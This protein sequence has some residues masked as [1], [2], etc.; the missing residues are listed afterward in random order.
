MLIARDWRNIVSHRFFN[1]INYSAS[2]EDSDSELQA[3]NISNADRVLCITGSGARTLDL[4][5]AVPASIT[6]VDLNP[7][8]NHLLALK[9]A[10]IEE[11]EHQEF[12]DFIGIGESAERLATFQ[13]I[14]PSLSLRS[15]EFWEKHLKLVRRGVIYC[16]T[17]ETLLRWISKSTVLRRQRIEQLWNAPDL[18]SQ[19]E[20]WRKHWTGPF[21]RNFLRLLATR[22][23]WTRIIRE[24]GAKLIDPKFDVGDYLYHAIEKMVR[25]SLIRENPYANLLFKGRYTEHCQLPPHLREEQFL[26]LKQLTYRIEIVTCPLDQLLADRPNSFD[27]FSLSDFSSYAP[28][29]AYHKI[30]KQVVYSAAKDSRFC[31]RQF[32][33]KRDFESSQLAKFNVARISRDV[34]LENQLQQM[35]HTC[36][37][38]FRAG[39]ILGDD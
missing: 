31:E 37:Y 5:T 30:W 7:T 15:R 11:L 24:P 27:A 39:T 18:E 16:G 10:A 19:K 12:L 20:H 25:H 33:V 22:F 9:I 23:L 6:S 32:L 1:Q 2:N 36:L 26:K 29:E 13:R 4:L 14:A 38:S 8:Q 17:W 3:L 21:L 35:D 28:I 34:N